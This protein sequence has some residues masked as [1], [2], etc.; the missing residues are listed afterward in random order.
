MNKIDYKSLEKPLNMLFK[1]E[2]AEKTAFKDEYTFKL[3]DIDILPDKT[4]FWSG[5][6]NIEILRKQ[7]LIDA[8][9][10]NDVDLF[11]QQISTAL[12]QLTLKIGFNGMP[13]SVEKQNELWQKWLV[14]RENLT[15]TYTG[16]WIDSTLIAVD[17]KMLPSETLTEYIKQDLFLNEYF[18][19]VYDANF[20]ENNFSRKREVYGLCPFPIW[21]NEKWTLQTSENQKLIKFSGNWTKNV[22]Q[23]RF[24]SWLK[25]KTDNDMT[26]VSVEGFYQIDPITGWCNALQSTYSLIANSSYLKTL[27]IILTTN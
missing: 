27:K 6:Q 18:R 8:L 20:V 1:V 16:D 12:H 5:H 9:P 26:E 19:G 15:N 14:I 21:F 17:K 4:S 3:F 13:V 2:I 22:D 10:D 25:T 7:S 11:V 24:D 23:P